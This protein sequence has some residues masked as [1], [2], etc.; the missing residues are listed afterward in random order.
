VKMGDLGDEL[1]TENQ[2]LDCDKI[3]TELSKKD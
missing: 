2:F 1:L 3:V